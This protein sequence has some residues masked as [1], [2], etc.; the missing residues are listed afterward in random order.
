MPPV[1]EDKIDIPRS[2]AVS[3]APLP[4]ARA[5][6]NAIHIDRNFEHKKFTHMVIV[7]NIFLPIS[8]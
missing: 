2:I 5:I 4:S 6:S 8:L 3:G 7:L 1:Y